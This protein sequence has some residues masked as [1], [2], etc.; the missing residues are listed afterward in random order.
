MWGYLQ[1]L[2][3]QLPCEHLLSSYFDRCYDQTWTVSSTAHLDFALNNSYKLQ[4]QHHVVQVKQVRQM[5][6]AHVMRQKPAVQAQCSHTSDQRG[7]QQ[8]QCPSFLKNVLSDFANFV[9]QQQS[10]L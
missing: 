10:V 1:H 2:S 6:H 5:C 8:P 4:G 9:L 3:I 7:V